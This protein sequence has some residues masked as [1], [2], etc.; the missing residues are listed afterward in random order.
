MTRPE[1]TSFPHLEHIIG[2]QRGADADGDS[3]VVEQVDVQGDL[4]RGGTL[5][6][7]LGRHQEPVEH[8]TAEH[9]AVLGHWEVRGKVVHYFLSEHFRP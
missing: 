8:L 5:S 2:L 1:K 9:P 3:V 4:L 7:Q 6:L